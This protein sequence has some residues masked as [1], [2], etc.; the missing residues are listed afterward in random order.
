M[1]CR[2]ASEE[3]QGVNHSSIRASAAVRM[4]RDQIVQCAPSNGLGAGLGQQGQ[5]LD[6]NRQWDQAQFDPHP[7]PAFRMK[8]LQ[9]PDPLDGLLGGFSIARLE[10]VSQSDLVDL[11]RLWPNIIAVLQE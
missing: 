4:G 5:M 6:G 11:V 7:I 10:G 8:L 9:F 1:G 2:E 3:A